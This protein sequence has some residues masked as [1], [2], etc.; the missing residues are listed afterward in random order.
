MF[1]SH[2]QRPLFPLSLIP[3]VNVLLLPPYFSHTLPQIFNSSPTIRIESKSEITLNVPL[4]TIYFPLS[5]YRY[6]FLVNEWRVLSPHFI[7]DGPEFNSIHVMVP[8]FKL[9]EIATPGS[10]SMAEVPWSK[11]LDPRTDEVAPR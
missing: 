11:P 2:Q 9:T 4:L 6:D 5:S 3:F 10:R 1:D 8:I 7:H